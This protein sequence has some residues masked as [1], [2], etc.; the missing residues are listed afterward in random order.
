[1][2]ILELNS[3]SIRM[4]MA[5]VES[6]DKLD[7]FGVRGGPPSGQYIDFPNLESRILESYRQNLFS[8]TTFFISKIE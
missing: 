8:E 1:M 2:G 4:A 5:A 7:L 3:S 6:L